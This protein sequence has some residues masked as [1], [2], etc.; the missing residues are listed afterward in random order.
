MEQKVNANTGA[1]AAGAVSVE[2]EAPSASTKNSEADAVSVTAGNYVLIYDVE[3]IV[4]SVRVVRRVLT[5]YAVD[6][7]IHAGERTAV[8]IKETKTGVSRAPGTG[9]APTDVSKYSASR[10]EQSVYAN[11]EN[12]RDYV[13]TAPPS[14][15]VHMVSRRTN[16]SYAILSSHVST[17]K[18][19][20]T[21]SSVIQKSPVNTVGISTSLVPAGSPTVSAVTASSIPTTPS[22]VAS[23]SKSTTWW[24][25]SRPT[26][27]IPLPSDVT[28]R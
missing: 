25:R 14:I 18:Y 19:A 7:V 1:V 15:C 4:W 24:M 22:P 3:S 20:I 12:E 26:F 17:I 10:A 6:V 23:A 13:G 11:T 9:Y 5:V 27:R 21:A 28:S 8:L 16:V 2:P